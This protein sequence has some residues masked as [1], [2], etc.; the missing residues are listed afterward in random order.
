MCVEGV[1]FTG[2]DPPVLIFTAGQSTGDVQCTN[3]SI[4]DD[5]ILNGERSFKIRLAKGSRGSSTG[6]LL[7]ASVGVINIDINHDLDDSKSMQLYTHG[8]L[9]VIINSGTGSV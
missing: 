9:I 4:I 3:V 5:S 7:S 8:T 2:P 1:D 6:V